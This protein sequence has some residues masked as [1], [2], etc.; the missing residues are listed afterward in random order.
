MKDEGIRSWEVGVHEREDRSKKT[1]RG[2]MGNGRDRIPG[3]LGCARAMPAP[4]PRQWNRVV[5]NP[6]KQRGD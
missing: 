6:Y 4:R 5:E 2:K 1:Q 3:G